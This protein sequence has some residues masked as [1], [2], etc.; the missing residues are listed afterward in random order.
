MTAESPVPRT[1]ETGILRVPDIQNDNMT[2]VKS[3]VID[4]IEAVPVNVECAMS[5]GIGIHLV[6]IPDNV[7]HEVLLRVITA[8]QAAGFGIPGKKIIINVSPVVIVNPSTIDAAIAAALIIESGQHAAPNRDIA[9]FGEL[10]LDGSL[11]ER[12][13]GWLATKEAFLDGLDG[14]IIPQWTAGSVADLCGKIH[15]YAARTIDEMLRALDGAPDLLLK[16]EPGV[17]AG[18]CALRLDIRTLRGIEFAASSGRDVILTGAG[19]AVLDAARLLYRLRPESDAGAAKAARSAVARPPA[20][21]GITVVKPYVALSGLLGGQT[22]GYVCP[23]YTALA[24]GG[25][26]V[27]EDFTEWPEMV[28]KALVRVHKSGEVKLTRLRR[29]YAFPTEFALVMTC[30]D[31]SCVTGERMRELAGELD[32]VHVN[33]VASPTPL[34]DEAIAAAAEHVRRCREGIFAR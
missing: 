1:V 32:V 5:S 27:A 4:G 23:G 20:D 31:S 7:A 25:V 22:D 18:A 11:R 3:Y 24:N 26:L 6:G 34:P 10:S 12:C 21:D 9:V 30:R 15:T 19:R 2:T 13:G 33:A 8:M 16:E 28:A 17:E 14:I 29:T